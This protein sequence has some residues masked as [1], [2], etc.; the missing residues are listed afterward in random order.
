MAW[1]SDGKTTFYIDSIPRKVYAYD[2]DAIQGTMSNQR[3]MFDFNAYPVSE[4][5]F[6]DGCCID[7]DDHLWV[8]CFGGSRVIEID[9]KSG[10]KLRDIMLP[11]Q[12]ITSCCWG[13]QG[14]ADLFVTSGVPA[15][16][17]TDVLSQTQPTAGS[18]FR[19][20][21]LGARGLPANIYLG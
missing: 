12:N 5:G 6:P 2:Y 15:G 9:T 19:I 17:P 4:L 18:V 11:T 14:H 3:V 13:G 1:T 7:A 20:T 8:A 21:G 16:I 10:T